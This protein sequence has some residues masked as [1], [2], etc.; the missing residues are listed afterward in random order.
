V[1]NLLFVLAVLFISFCKKQETSVSVKPKI[2]KSVNP[3]Q[4]IFVVPMGKTSDFDVNYIVNELKQ[5]YKCNVK[6]L[7]KVETPAIAKVKGLKKYRAVDILNFLSTKYK[8]N[9]GK[10]LALTDVDICTDRELNGVVYKNWGVFGLGRLNNKPCVISTNRFKTNY[11]D[12]LSKVTIHEIGHT[13]GL[14]HCNYDK[15]CL[16][17]DAKGKG[18]KVDSEKKWM[19]ENCRKIIGIN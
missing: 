3:S 11:Y 14:E 5:F 1:K 13:L 8:N 7:P 6:I 12:R 18:G 4:T 19:C 16:M 10:V 9:N 15:N 2:V 17:N